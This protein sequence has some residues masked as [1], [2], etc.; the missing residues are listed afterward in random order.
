MNWNKFTDSYHRE[1]ISPWYHNIPI[2]PDLPD[3]RIIAILDESKLDAVV[4][5]NEYKD[6]IHN[7]ETVAIDKDEVVDF[8][9][10]NPGNAI[11]LI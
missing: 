6:R 8:D 3:D 11:A 4:T 9:G 7:F 5:S 2:N 1:F 10:D